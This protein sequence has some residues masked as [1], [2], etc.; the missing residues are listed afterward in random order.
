M[1]LRVT[2]VPG[3]GFGTANANNTRS[4]PLAKTAKTTTA[5]ISDAPGNRETKDAPRHLSKQEFGQR[6]RKKMLEKGMHHAEL[7]RRADLPRNNVSTYINGRSFP[8]EISLNKLAKALGCTADELL[9][10]RLEMA[11]RGEAMPDLS[12]KTSVTDQSRSWLVVNRL[13]S[14]GL[15]ARIIQMLEDE[16]AKEAN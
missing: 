8:S 16:R 11:I 12:M 9:P 14:T 2:Y 13:V 7:A 3:K 5:V 10:N 1:G 15:A 6:L 4:H